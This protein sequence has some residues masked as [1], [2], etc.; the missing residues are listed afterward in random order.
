MTCLFDKL[1]GIIPDVYQEVSWLV[2]M[3]VFL[4]SPCRR[5][6]PGFRVKCFGPAFLTS[7]I[8]VSVEYHSSSHHLPIH[9][10]RR[11]INLQSLLS[12]FQRSSWDCVVC[13]LIGGAN[14]AWKLLE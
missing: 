4:I 7:F 13:K 14:D 2:D 9:G 5:F 6:G 8:S 1:L 11:P 10:V 12:P 3:V